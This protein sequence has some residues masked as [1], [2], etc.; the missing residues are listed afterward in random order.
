M[1]R[2]EIAWLEEGKSHGQNPHP[3]LMTKKLILLGFQTLT[4]IKY[5]K[6]VIWFYFVL[7]LCH[8]SFF[9]FSFFSW[10]ISNIHHMTF[11]EWI[12]SFLF[13]NV[14]C[15][16]I[17][18]IIFYTSSDRSQSGKAMKLKLFLLFFFQSKL[19]ETLV[20]WGNT[21]KRIDFPL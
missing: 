14:Y 18:Y 13:L 4:L 2:N 5:L 8:S 1:V 10:N 6:I 21:S 12:F 11:L 9:P 16:C 7:F 19:S 17:F 15:G 3:I 20:G